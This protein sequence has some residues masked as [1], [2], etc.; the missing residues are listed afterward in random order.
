MTSLPAAITAT[1]YAPEPHDPFASESLRPSTLRL[2]RRNS[3][4]THLHGLRDRCKDAAGVLTIDHEVDHIRSVTRAKA[5]DEEFSVAVRERWQTWS[6][7]ANPFRTDLASSAASELN[8]SAANSES[9]PED[10][11]A[12]SATE[13]ADEQEEAE[14]P[15]K[16][17]RRKAF[18]AEEIKIK[19]GESELE[20]TE[21]WET[22][23]RDREACLSGLDAAL[24]S[25]FRF[26]ER[27][28]QVYAHR[29]KP[30]YINSLDR[31]FEVRDVRRLLRPS[32]N[33]VGAGVVVA[34]SACVFNGTTEVPNVLTISF[35]TGSLD[36][37]KDDAATQ[38]TTDP[39][40][41]PK[42][43]DGDS[44]RDDYVKRICGDGLGGMKRTQTVELI[45]SQTLSDL[46]NSLF[47]WSD[48]QP[49]R[50]GWR[51]RLKRK[52][53]NP[54]GTQRGPELSNTR[55]QSDPAN[56]A[57]SECE[58]ND[59]DER[60]SDPR[61]ARF[62][63]QRRQTDTVLIIEDKMYNK[64]VRHGDALEEADYAALL[65][66][67]KTAPGQTNASVGWA[68]KA[69]DL[70][71]SIDQLNS[72]RVGQPYWLLHQGDCVHCFVIEQVRAM[73][74][75][76]QTWL[77]DTSKTMTSVESA[78]GGSTVIG[79]PR[80]TWLSTPT[81][82][83]FTADNKDSYSIGHRILHLDTQ[84]PSGYD[85]LNEQGG[86]S[87]NSR[88]AESSQPSNPWQIALSRTRR[89]EEGLLRKKQGKCL[90]CSLRKAQVGI[91][92]GDR[93]RLPS[94]TVENHDND[95][96]AQDERIVAGL[97]DHLTTLCT[98]CAALLGLPTRQSDAA[99]NPEAALELNW[100][101][102]DADKSRQAGWTVFPMY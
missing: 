40:G 36:F 90:A 5:L 24:P 22:I 77:A 27:Q 72:F 25:A 65:A 45:S 4:L 46:Q 13:D 55:H 64:G 76:E 29:L 19:V 26:D 50:C 10:S 21:G 71:I 28:L 87:S 74:P 44:T 98:S 102:I 70:N 18:R 8:R 15:S 1:R 2:Q 81:M 93:V 33:I 30:K 9:D 32:Q 20:M 38:D 39:S 85:E 42:E 7:N 49:E 57:G 35:F 56:E 43:L 52:H 60:N 83:R 75:R 79:F 61:F 11:S 68:E 63:G 97:D 34:R 84:V 95:A 12:A 17:K 48:E 66:Q 99:E 41:S 53:L 37:G 6:R 94:N 89:K 96:T 92:G 54:R 91:L 47:C 86:S 88:E 67:W 82:L 58:S 31:P 100:Q 51:K 62:T 101:H 59:E 78:P 69:G 23:R 80:V 73:R 14:H 3:K 16:R